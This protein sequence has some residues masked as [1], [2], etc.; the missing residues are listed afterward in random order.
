MASFKVYVDSQ[1]YGFRKRIA[2]EQD[3]G[4]G[5]FAYAQPVV[6]EEVDR[7]RSLIPSAFDE[8]DAKFNVRK[9][10]VDSFLQSALDAAW[11]QG[12]RPTGAP[13]PTNELAAVRDHLEDMRLLVKVS[14]KRRDAP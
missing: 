1:D 2:I 13:D 6:F 11:A 7:S 9:G 10:L 3:L 5:Q 12:L 8:A 14:R 4:G